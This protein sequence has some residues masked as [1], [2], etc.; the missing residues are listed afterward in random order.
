MWVVCA[1]GFLRR[2]DIEAIPDSEF[3]LK[4][5]LLNAIQQKEI[6][7]NGG[8][9]I[10]NPRGKY[11]AGPLINQEGII[12]ATVDPMVA[13]QERQNFD[14]SGHYS[15]KDVLKLKIRRSLL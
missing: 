2:S 3:P 15:R 11:V 1:S 5:K 6:L 14:H 9:V 7:Y 4:K 13:I 8:S 12:Y 10:V